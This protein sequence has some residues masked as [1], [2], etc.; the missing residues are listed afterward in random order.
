MP[1][2]S[3]YSFRRASWMSSTAASLLRGVQEAA[4]AAAARFRSR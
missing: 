1:S 3:E 4:A 2:D